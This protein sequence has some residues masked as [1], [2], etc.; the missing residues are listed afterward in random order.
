MKQ[1]Q[2]P[3]PDVIKYDRDKEKKFVI[4][5]NEQNALQAQYI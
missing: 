4:K 5:K 3:I 1:P 2:T